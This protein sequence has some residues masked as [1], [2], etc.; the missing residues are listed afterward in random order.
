MYKFLL[1]E[2][3]LSKRDNYS[4]VVIRLNFQKN[5]QLELSRDDNI[6][7]YA[8]LKVQKLKDVAS[9]V[10]A[11]LQNADDLNLK[12]QSLVY[13]LFMVLNMRTIYGES[14]DQLQQ[15]VSTDGSVS[16]SNAVK[17]TTAKSYLTLPSLR[18]GKI[19]DC[20]S[21]KCWEE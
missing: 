9:V 20:Y 14:G 21:E 7:I 6:R 12:H 1:C 16:Q 11:L 3:R 19:V 13:A 10:Q 5:L 2:L 8:L 18:L 15:D 17:L 4:E